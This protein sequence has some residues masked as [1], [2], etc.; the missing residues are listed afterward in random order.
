MDAEI[1]ALVTA[2]RA[3]YGNS[4]K[5]HRGILFT[6]R[7]EWEKQVKADKAAD[8]QP[9]PETPAADTTETVTVTE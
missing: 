9:A 7:A 6:F 5:A 3:K 4:D 2:C 8:S 1:A